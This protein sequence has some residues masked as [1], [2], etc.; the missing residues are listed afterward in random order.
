MALRSLPKIQVPIYFHVINKGKTPADGNVVDQRLIDQV[1]VMNKYY[2]TMNV[3]FTL[4]GT[5]RTTSAK[6]QGGSIGSTEESDMKTKLHKGDV[7]TLNVYLTAATDGTL[8]WSSFPWDYAS[9]PKM[10]GIVI[11]FETV[12]GGAYAQYN[13][14]ITLVHETGHWLGLY[15]TFQ[16]GCSGGDDIADTPAEAGPNFGCPTTAPDTCSSDPGDDPIHNFMDYSDDVC[17]TDFTNGQ[18]QR[19]HDSFQTYR[20]N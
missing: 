4:A 14:G 20:Q 12:P 7:G 13:L 11:H 10:D 8:G 16:G 15:H 18:I 17:L 1:D 6:W 5:D 3:S 2:K 9:E 19:V